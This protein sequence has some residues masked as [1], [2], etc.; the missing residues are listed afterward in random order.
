[1]FLLFNFFLGYSSDDYPWLTKQLPQI[2]LL[3]L[4]IGAMIYHGI[5]GFVSTNRSTFSVTLPKM[6]VEV[7]VANPDV[8]QA[9]GAPGE[10]VAAAV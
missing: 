5:T 9:A 3:I 1:M 4:M 2:P 7:P 6:Q 8:R 10:A